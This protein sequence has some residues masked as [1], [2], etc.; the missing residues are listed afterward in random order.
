MTKEEQFILQKI[1]TQNEIDRQFYTKLALSIR[2]SIQ[3]TAS[4]RLL[5]L[6]N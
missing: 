3:T 6:V 2:I 1:Y 4:N 5:K